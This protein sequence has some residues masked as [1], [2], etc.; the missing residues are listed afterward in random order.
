MRNF[1]Q[2]YHHLAIVFDFSPLLSSR[3]GTTVGI[4][5]RIKCFYYLCKNN[6]LKVVSYHQKKVVFNTSKRMADIST[7]DCGAE[8]ANFMGIIGEV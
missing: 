2:Y 8:N 1:D 7:R 5:L 4:A 3:E 6:R